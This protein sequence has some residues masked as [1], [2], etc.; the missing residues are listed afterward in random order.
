MVRCW[1]CR[2]RRRRKKRSR[3][4]IRANPATLPTTLPTIVGVGAVVPSPEPAAAVVDDEGGPPAVPVGPPK[5]PITPLPWPVFDALAEDK[6]D[7]VVK[8]ASD[9]VVEDE[10][11]LVVEVELENV[12][13]VVEEPEVVRKV[14]KEVEM[15]VVEFELEVTMIG[16]VVKP[17]LV[18][19]A[20]TAGDDVSTALAAESIA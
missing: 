8:D 2:F 3:I 17:E 18:C 19:A 5:P 1:P 6:L 20:V 14:L 12:E 16:S 13:F 15:T 10:L 7:E 9:D 4:R 11:V